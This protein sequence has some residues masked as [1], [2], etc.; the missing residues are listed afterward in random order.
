MIAE[1]EQRRSPRWVAVLV[2]LLG[3]L[4]IV[5]ALSLWGGLQAIERGWVSG[6]SFTLKLGTFHVMAR[7]TD[8]PQCMFLP[9]QECM[10]SFPMANSRP[11][12][13]AIWA[14]H[15]TA[16]PPSGY[17]AAY[18]VS[19]GRMLFLTVLRQAGL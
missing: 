3:A 6:P 11:L 19:N 18:T 16:V 5:G 10:I 1:E 17:S 13:Y 7:T 14:G 15:I 4:L 8:R 12:T 2:S 9:L